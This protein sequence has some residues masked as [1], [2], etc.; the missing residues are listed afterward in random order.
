MQFG[1]GVEEGFSTGPMDWRRLGG[2]GGIGGILVLTSSRVVAPDLEYVVCAGSN[3]DDERRCG[4]LTVVLVIWSGV[5][6]PRT[7]R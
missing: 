2:I 7:P 1:A 5:D 3:D 6:L 4:Q